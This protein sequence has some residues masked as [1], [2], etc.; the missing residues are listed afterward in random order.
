LSFL[1]AGIPAVAL[2]AWARPARAQRGD[3]LGRIASFAVPASLAVT[4]IGLLLFVVYTI[5]VFEVARGSVTVDEVN[6]TLKDT[7]PRA[8][9]VVVSFLT[10]CGLLLVMFVEP[11]SRF[12]AGRDEPSGDRR[13]TWLAIAL[14]L[15]LLAVAVVPPLSWIFDL[16]A[17]K[18][19]DIAVIVAAAAVW[20]F[21][22][23]LAWRRRLLERFLGTDPEP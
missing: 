7:L 2:A 8:Q 9:T 4:L 6:A 13:P 22:V 3:T 15:G 17:V 23:R 12:W 16:R 14:L 5:P 20:V 18:L 1:T 10:V 11:P 21:L 19:L